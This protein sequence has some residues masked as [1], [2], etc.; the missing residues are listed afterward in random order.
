MAVIVDAMQNALC[1]SAVTLITDD[2][3]GMDARLL[4][5]LRHLE[6]EDLC[7][8]LRRPGGTVL[9]DAAAIAGEGNAQ[10]IKP[11]TLVSQDHAE[12]I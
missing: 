8:V 12:K 10:I 5:L 1:V 9:N 6:V 2:V 11:G 7:K 4:H 3:Q